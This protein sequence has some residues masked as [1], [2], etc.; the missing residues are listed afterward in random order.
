ML[1]HKRLGRE[2]SPATKCPASSELSLFDSG[3]IFVTSDSNM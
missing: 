2:L 3:S 1:M